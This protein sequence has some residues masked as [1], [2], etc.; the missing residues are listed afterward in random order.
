MDDRLIQQLRD[1]FGLSE[2]QTNRL[3]AAAAGVLE[4][5][6]HHRLMQDLHGLNQQRVNPVLDD[7]QENQEN[8]DPNWE[9]I[10]LQNAEARVREL[11]EEMRVLE[12]QARIEREEHR[13]R[14]EELREQLRIA[15]E[16]ERNLEQ[17]LQNL[18]EMLD[19]LEEFL[20]VFPEDHQWVQQLLLEMEALERNPDL[21]RNPRDPQLRMIGAQLRQQRLQNANQREQH[22]HNLAIPMENEIGRDVGNADAVDNANDDNVIRP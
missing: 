21:A 11:L 16:R 3:Y 15:E 18:R 17:A 6:Q 9:Q 22:E 12:E 7:N 2:E 5:D 19:D 20:R 14:Q 13:I 10:G 8:Q 4:E 1:E